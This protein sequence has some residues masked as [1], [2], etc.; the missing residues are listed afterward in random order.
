MRTSMI[1]L[2]TLIR[3]KEGGDGPK[4]YGQV[5]GKAKPKSVLLVDCSKLTVDGVLALQKK[6]ID[7]GSGSTACAGYQFIRRTLK[8][9]KG[10]MNLSG[11]ELMSPELQDRMALHLMQ[12]RGLYR[13]LNGTISAEAFANNL[14]MEWASLPVVTRLFNPAKGYKRWL[15]PGQ[16]YWQGDG[17]NAAHHKPEVFL[18]AVKALRS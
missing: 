9:I 6:M 17:M 8:T 16:S 3:S 11:K 14:A 5:Y 7:N 4:G 10:Q 18:A 12:G 2:L 13:Y 1:S 15:N